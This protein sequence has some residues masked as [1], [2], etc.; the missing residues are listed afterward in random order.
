MPYHR[1]ANHDRR[2]TTWSSSS[3]QLC[4]PLWIL[5]I[6]LA[7]AGYVQ[8][9]YTPPKLHDSL[10]PAT[11]LIENY[12]RT[13][14]VSFLHKVDHGLRVVS[15]PYSE[16]PRKSDSTAIVLNWSRFPNVRRIASLLCSFELADI[17]DTIMIWNNSPIQI[18]YQVSLS[19]RFVYW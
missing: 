4:I 7:I 15:I 6:S 2:D 19:C 13:P 12:L 10:P 9:Q 18:S 8:F 11:V 1:T 3:T 16:P 14:V 5:V 17:F